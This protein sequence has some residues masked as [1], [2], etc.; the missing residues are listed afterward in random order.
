[1]NHAT[2][3]ADM[4]DEKTIGLAEILALRNSF[5]VLNAGWASCP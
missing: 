1:M 4:G 3:R 5:L 2:H